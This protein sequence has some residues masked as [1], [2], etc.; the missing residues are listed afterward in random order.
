M[1]LRFQNLLRK[2]KVVSLLAFNIIQFFQAL[3]AVIT[4]TVGLAFLAWLFRFQGWLIPLISFLVA[5][6]LEFLLVIFLLLKSSPP[7]WILGGYKFVK[8]EVYYV[9]DEND[10]QHHTQTIEFEIEAIKPG[11]SIF[12]DTYHWT[13]H[14]QEGEP[15]VVSPGHTTMG[16]I[17]RQNG[18]KYCYIHLGQ[19]LKVGRRTTVKTVQSLYDSEKSFEPFLARVVSTPT[20]VLI[21]HA[22]LPKAL[23][24]ANIFFRQ[25]NT[26]GPASRVIEEKAGKIDIHSGEIRWEIP[27]PVFGHRYSIDWNYQ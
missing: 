10:H 21:L 4:T 14:G 7:R 13:G 16:N 20:D 23:F 6:F 5:I 8:I 25:W 11:V 9:I 12:E 18:W 26:V 27:S 2:L 17:I 3:V 24:P 19:E 1:E 15:K 22:I